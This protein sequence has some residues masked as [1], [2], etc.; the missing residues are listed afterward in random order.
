M[1]KVLN[2]PRLKSGDFIEFRDSKDTRYLVKVVE[3][4]GDRILCV[5]E[6]SND[7]VLDSDGTLEIISPYS[8]IFLPK[9]L[10]EQLKSHQMRY[11]ILMNTI[12]LKMMKDGLAKFFEQR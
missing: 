1:V 7:Y 8:R 6:D 5:P 3:V 12:S 9:G 2:P 10:W 11:N 4:L